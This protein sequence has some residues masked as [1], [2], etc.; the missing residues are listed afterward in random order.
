MSNSSYSVLADEDLGLDDLYEDSGGQKKT[1]AP[2]THTNE[3]TEGIVELLSA[4]IREHEK[5]KDMKEMD[6]D[7]FQLPDSNDGSDP[8]KFSKEEEPQLFQQNIALIRS[9]MKRYIT[10]S[11]DCEDSLDQMVESAAYFGFLKAVRSYR[12]SYAITG[13]KFSTWATTC[14][15]NQIISDL[16]GH[17]RKN[18][19]QSSLEDKVVKKGSSQDD[20]SLKDTLVAPSNIEQEAYKSI[21]ID[22]LYIALGM[23][24]PMDRDVI[25]KLYGIGGDCKTQKEI[26]DIYHISQSAIST[27]KVRILG[28]LRAILMSRFG[29]TSAS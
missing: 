25:T 12:K 13:C 28:R 9:V 27:M 15:N 14:M 24:E 10:H 18:W 17:R 7:N 1:E 4:V 23:L 22:Y 26:G 2:I 21:V 11:S 29:V 3:D 8:D 5:E 20:I 16:K 19:R 6:D